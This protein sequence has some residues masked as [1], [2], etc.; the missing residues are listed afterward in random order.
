MITEE[1]AVLPDIAQRIIDL[2]K[3]HK[4]PINIIEGNTTD[5][6][7]ELTLEVEYKEDEHLKAWIV[8]RAN[9]SYLREE[10]GITDEDEFED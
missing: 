3:K 4:L 10:H 7:Q 9:N 5:S 6:L 2:Q 1:I 8:N